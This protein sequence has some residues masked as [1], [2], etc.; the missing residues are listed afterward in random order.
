MN[1]DK[2]YVCCCK[3]DYYFTKI[4]VASIRY[5]N[6]TIPIVLLKD[7]SQGN[8]ST[9][10]MEKA[11]S[12]SLAPLKLKNLYAYCKLFPFM[13]SADERVLVIDSDIVWLNDIVSSLEQFDEDIIVDGYLPDISEDEMGKWYFNVQNLK[14]HYPNYK[15]PGF[16]FNAGQMV[17]NTSKFNEADFK[18]VIEWKENMAP[19]INDVFLCEDQGIINYIVATNLKNKGLSVRLHHFFYW[20]WSQKAKKIKT[21]DIR[22]RKPHQYLIHWYGPKH[23]LISFLPNSSLLKFYEAFYYSKINFGSIR[24]YTDRLARTIFHFPAFTYEFLKW[25]YLNLKYFVSRHN[26]TN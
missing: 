22:S 17:F 16:L 9:H 1:I 14:K 8:F 25:L 7:L 6:A 23:G 3:K 15:F 20:G 13:Q 19:L 4:C 12:V 18:N 5:W 2:V 21:A 11:F 24:I 26:K 10:E